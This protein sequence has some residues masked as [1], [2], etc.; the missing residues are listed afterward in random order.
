MGGSGKSLVAWLLRL[1]LAV[2]TDGKHQCEKND[3]RREIVTLS[4]E[5][6]KY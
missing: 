6:G 3:V 1:A 4:V 5:S 2:I